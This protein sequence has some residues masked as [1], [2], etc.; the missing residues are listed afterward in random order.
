MAIEVLDA[1]SGAGQDE[2]AL[3]ARLCA[4]V[5][6]LNSR[7]RS[8][9]LT[10][11]TKSVA[12]TAAQ[13][14][15]LANTVAQ[16]QLV[17]A[18]IIKAQNIA[19]VGE[20]DEPHDPDAPDR[21]KRGAFKSNEDFL[22]AKLGIARQEAARRFQL[23]EATEARPVP[24]GRPAAPPRLP[25]LA[26][27][28]D[29]GKVS[30]QAANLIRKA[31][32]GLRRTAEPDQLR[33]MEEALVKHASDYD[34]D[35]LRE[36]IRY[37]EGGL[38]PG[39]AD[40]TAAELKSRQGLFYRGRRNGLHC[41][42]IN[43]TDEQNE[44]LATV[45]NTATNPR[46]REGTA[47]AG[48][49]GFAG[50][51]TPGAAP[52]TGDDATGEDA[53]GYLPA[54]VDPLSRT[55][56]GGNQPDDADPAAAT[57][58]DLDGRTRQQ[59]QLDGLI[60]AC[61][62]A[63]TTDLLPAA[64]G[65]RPQLL[66]TID[67]KDLA[68]D[69]GRP[70]TGTFSGALSAKTIRRIACDADIIPVVLAGMGVILDVGQ[71]QRLFPKYLRLAIIARDGG[72][73]FPGCTAPS[74]WTEVHHIRWFEKGGPTST[75]NGVM[76]CSHHHHLIHEGD[77]R[78]EV[79]NGVA[80]FFPPPTLDPAQ[81]PLRNHAWLKNAQLPE[82]QPEPV[83]VGQ[84]SGKSGGPLPVLESAPHEANAPNL[85]AHRDG[86]LP[87]PRQEELDI[88]MPGATEPTRPSRNF[89]PFDGWPA[90]PQTPPF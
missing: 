77:W 53:A 89:S 52:G 4:E 19:A 72:C 41:Y 37:W 20:T 83:T 8:G 15:E 60:G 11:S 51:G 82:R 26:R 43:A 85:S 67:Y 71:S 31:V 40:P 59:K 65:R 30:G 62:V 18:R 36:L 87:V 28:L 64:G 29:D 66:A 49:V 58:R 10:R 5:S 2:S 81:K 27:A 73:A 54:A 57:G 14:E 25:V 34:A 23:A 17:L 35:S 61:K 50:T 38:N 79:I 3:L 24:E 68:T 39:G 21:P 56:A 80:W 84:W 88:G 44:V 7:L 69:L 48:T 90:Q 55:A 22:R 9:G 46:L 42:E 1:A 63:L 75:D 45:Y 12:R 32:D 78:I 74:P 13:V 76:L 70:G 16:T 86:P 33:K 47:T 6:G